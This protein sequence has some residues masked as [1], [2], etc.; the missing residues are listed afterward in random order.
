L[1]ADPAYD[2][3]LLDELNIALRNDYLDLAGVLAVLASRPKD[4]HICITGRDAKPELVQI[5]DLV[6]T[7]T[8]VTHPYETGYR[9]QKGVEF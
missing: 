9:A 4:K 3:V 8:V 7:M 5:A 6:T 2:F 1:I